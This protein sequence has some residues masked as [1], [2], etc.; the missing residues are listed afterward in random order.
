MRRRRSLALALLFA[1][2]GCWTQTAPFGTRPLDSTSA[3]SASLRSAP[4]GDRRSTP[5]Q[6]IVLI[7]QENRS[8]N[9]LF[10]T[11]PGAMGTTT[12]N[13]R[14]GSGSEAKTVPIALKEA[15]LYYH[16]DLSHTYP[17]WRVAYRDGHMDAFNLILGRHG[18]PEG[19]RPYQYV[20]PS[21]VAPYWTMAQQYALADEMFQ[22]Q[23][24][25]SFTAHQDLIRGGTA[26]GARRSLIDD[27]TRAPWG[28]TAP[29]GTRTSLITTRLYYEPNEGPYPCLTYETLADLLDANGIS[30]KYYTPSWHLISG[31]QWNAFLAIKAVYHDRTEWNAHISTPDTKIFS[32]ISNN[33]L[34]AMSWVIPDAVNSDHP[35]YGSDT[36]PSW[37]AS[38]V[39]AIGES[40]YW[41]STAVVVVWD[42]W[43]GFYDPVR[44]PKRDDQGG[45]GFRVGMIVISPYVPQGEI[46][47]TVYEFGSIVRF[48]EDTWNLGRLGTT[49]ET[50]TS[51]ANIFDFSQSPRTFTAIPS[52]YSRAFFLRQKPSGLPVDTE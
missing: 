19:A 9:N 31:A 33:A 20:D 30:W 12:G 39:N 44:P 52:S 7:V 48:I 11:F 13:E 17:S 3:G 32:D 6:H 25:Q 37:V 16:I 18:T 10:A 46:S 4:H 1:L 22:T 24:S 2:S 38:V 41:S 28:C 49:D 40:S 5:I 8:F 36:G 42:D 50:C 29:P 26:I 21:Q 15:A 27:P 51:I 23:G 45:P 43:G 34:P 35:G 14:I 47:S